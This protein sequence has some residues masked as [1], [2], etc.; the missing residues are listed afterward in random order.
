MFQSGQSV[1]LLHGSLAQGHSILFT[2]VLKPQMRLVGTGEVG[3]QLKVVVFCQLIGLV[4]NQG[5][6]IS[7]KQSTC[8]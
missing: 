7:R 6:L 8:V 4:H 2:N 1:F 3:T 5:R